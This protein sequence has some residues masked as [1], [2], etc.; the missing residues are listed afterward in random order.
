LVKRRREGRLGLAQLLHTNFTSES[1]T[2]FWHL[3]LSH[4]TMVQ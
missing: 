3:P 4:G 1:H 2:K